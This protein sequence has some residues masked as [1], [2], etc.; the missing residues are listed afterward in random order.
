MLAALLMV[1]LS[2]THAT[3]RRL[4][5]YPWGVSPDGRVVFGMTAK[6]APCFW[7]AKHGL[8]VLDLPK[9]LSTGCVFGASSDGAVLVGDAEI[10][11]QGRP[12]CVCRWKNGHVSIVC[13]NPMNEGPAISSDGS[14][15]VGT[16]YV[17]SSTEG[18]TQRA[19]R[20][21]EST[22]LQFLKPLDPTIKV[23]WDSA[24]A[25]SND[26][27][28]VFGTS[29]TQPVGGAKS[30]LRSPDQG[31][32]TA[33]RWS[34]SGRAEGLPRAFP[35]LST[36]ANGCSETGSVVIGDGGSSRLAVWARGGVQI[37]KGP[38]GGMEG[39]ANAV[40]A[41]GRWILGSEF[42]NDSD[43]VW[44]DMQPR[45]LGDYLKELGIKSISS[46]E[47]KARGISRD[48]RVIV[49][50]GRNTGQGWILIVNK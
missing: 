17:V 44:H 45:R 34:A 33:C 35:G 18:G 8:T 50:A 48:G 12:H 27:S 23:P 15:I 1:T 19:F 36:Y 28:L 4:N 11:G 5:F 13:L 37:L 3:L 30:A 20:W 38:D 22:G 32:F 43:L 39:K 6:E 46:I 10:A 24:V 41:D 42:E 21:R 14:T 49:G 2:T 31:S 29:Q 9:G 47:L 25:V 26:G 40:S 7:T 16:Q